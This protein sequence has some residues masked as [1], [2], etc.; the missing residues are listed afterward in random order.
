MR[1]LNSTEIRERLRKI[2][3]I[4]A[5][6]D[7]T[8]LNHSNELGE[9]TVDIARKLKAKGV[10]LTFVTQRIHSSVV[11]HAKILDIQIP[12]I[13][14]NGAMI[15]DLNGKVISKTL[16]SPKHVDKALAF[17]KKYYIRIALV[18]NDEIVYTE[19]NSV[20]K[21]YMYRLGTEYTLIDSYDNYKDD[22]LEIIMMGNE[23]VVVKHVQNKMNFPMKWFLVA[24]Y[25]RSN[26]RLGVYNLEIRRSGMNKRKGLKIL[27]K[28]LNVK[29][30]EVAVL[31][32]WFNDRELFDYGAFNVALQNSVAEL[33][34]KSHIVTERTNEED[35]VGEFLKLLY[36]S[37]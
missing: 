32:D 18:Y 29:K 34:F 37:L 36:D 15:K 23:K 26:S 2:K 27:A 21:D 20:L 31:G 7:G 3:L 17:C 25:Y 28:Y 1:K 33:K 4:A 22:V 14:V 6:V 16:I 12:L 8:L 30:H 19:D 5:D 9:M 11:P 24:K 35:G 10:N 13:T